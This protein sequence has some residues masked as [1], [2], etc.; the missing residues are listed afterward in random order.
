MV[1]NASDDL[2]EPDRPVMTTSASRGS[3]T[4]TSLRLCSR[5][6]ETTI[7]ACRDT[8]SSVRNA[9][10]DLSNTRSGALALCGRLRIG[11]DPSRSEGLPITSLAPS[12]AVQFRS[13]FAARDHGWRFWIA[14]WI[15]TAVAELLALRPFI[16]GPVDGIGVVFA[17][18]GGS[19][20]VFG[21]LAWR[22]R[23]DSL[24]GALMTATG[25]LFFVS[26]V[27]GPLEAPLAFT[28][29]VLLVDLWIF[30]FV[31]LLLTFLTAG[32]LQPGFDRWLVASFALPVIVLQLAWLLTADRVDGTDLRGRNLLLV[33]PDGDF[34]HAVDRVQRGSLA[35]LGAI[36]VVVIV[37]RWIRASGPRR[38]AMLPSLAGA[39]ALSC[40]VA[41][42]VNDLIAGTRSEVLL[43]C[44]ACSLV[45]VPAAFLRPAAVPAGAR[46]PGGARPRARLRPR[47][48]ARAGARADAGRPRPARR[49]LAA[50]VRRVR[51]R[52]R[53]SGRAA[54]AG[55][56]AR[57]GARRT[58]RPAR[59]GADPRRVAHR[60]PRAAR[61]GHRGCRDRAG[62]RP[63]ARGVGR[64]AR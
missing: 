38:R 53:T 16:T 30:P 17:L 40:F 29:Y 18:V 19:F 7:W 52:G 41:L 3:A 6:P 14:L 15:A 44:A 57:R 63:S 55:R 11:S 13:R 20:C 25:F 50:R 35:L 24:S 43:W 60:R 37:A 59:R 8:P 61:G 62:E 64:P 46:R 34:A 32:R 2:P 48:G 22:R 1:S 9:R 28:F 39:I 4:V 26:P 21:L 56:G 31:A 47:R 5:A 58:R 33:F 45:A 27:L 12:E 51:G 10:T 23:P 54:R 36:T 49:L 42:L